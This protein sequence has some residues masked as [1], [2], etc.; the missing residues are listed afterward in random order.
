VMLS[1]D[2]LFAENS[3]VQVMMGQGITPAGHHPITRQMDDRALADFLGGIRK[4]AARTA[5]RLPSHGD[6]VRHFCPATPPMDKPMPPAPELRINPA[7]RVE[8]QHL[9]DGSAVY[10]VDD[11]A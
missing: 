2:E 6:Y 5:M 9:A 4:D 10:I 7:A 1:A 8:V 3:W 11:F